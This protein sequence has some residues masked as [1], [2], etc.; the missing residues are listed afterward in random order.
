MTREQLYALV[1]TT[2]MVHAAAKYGLSGNGLAKICRKLDVP[3]PPRGWW[4]KKAAGTPVRQASLPKLKTGIPAAIVVRVREHE[5]QAPQADLSS[6]RDQLND[7]AVPERLAKAHPVIA[8]WRAERERQRRE[9][10]RE[11]D[12]WVR[13]IRSVPE[14]TDIEK[15][16]HRVFHALLRALEKGGAVVADGDKQGHVLITVA[17]E[18]IDLEIRE[19]LKQVKRPLNEDEQRWEADRSRLVTELVGTG[20]LH[21]VIH[22]WSRGGLKREWL[23]SDAHP[24]DSLLPEIAATVL[25]MGPHLAEVR[26]Q[27]EEE[28]RVAEERRRQAEEERRR[29]KR[30]ANRWLRFVEFARAAQEVRAARLLLTELR[31]QA[32]ADAMVGDRPLAEWLDWVEERATALDPLQRGPTSLFSEIA[33]VAEWSYHD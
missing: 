24:I 11:R 10:A 13:Q 14:F 2:P 1:L 32:P 21:V 8:G 7:I 3:Y 31:A 28:V 33:D 16:M 4:A 25:A 12:P 22:T 26:R 6:V 27:R 29:R 18:Q 15:K 5:P 9:A 20:R 19:K 30:D 17:G 23:E